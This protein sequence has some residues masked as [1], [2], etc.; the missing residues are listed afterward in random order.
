[1]TENHLEMLLY[2]ISAFQVI[3]TMNLYYIFMYLFLIYYNYIIFYLLSENVSL[4]G[5]VSYHMSLTGVSDSTAFLKRAAERTIPSVK[6]ASLHDKLP[7]IP[8]EFWNY[9]PVHPNADFGVRY[10]EDELEHLDKKS[11]KSNDK[12][13]K[14]PINLSIATESTSTRQNSNTLARFGFKVIGSPTDED[15][16][17]TKKKVTVLKDWQKPNTPLLLKT[18]EEISESPYEAGQN[19]T[20]STLVASVTN[21]DGYNAISHYPF[22]PNGLLDPNGDHDYEDSNNYFGEFCNPIDYNYDPPGDEPVEALNDLQLIQALAKKRLQEAEDRTRPLDLTSEFHSSIKVALQNPDQ[23]KF[24]NNRFA[25]PPLYYQR[26]SL[27][28]PGP[29]WCTN[30]CALDS[31]LVV[32]LSIRIALKDEIKFADL[33]DRAIDVMDKE[34]PSLCALLESYLNCEIDNIEFKE[35]ALDLFTMDDARWVK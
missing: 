2:L 22:Q 24:Q 28:L 33:Y 11:K 4:I 3:D 34:F 20:T 30:K 32:L 25:T 29:P 18:D 13:K 35:A 16:V 23:Y 9:Y 12:P 21:D 1:M 10:Y 14:K 5:W 27:L 31:L 8:R 15:A 26:G 17:P 6:L 19:G 7:F